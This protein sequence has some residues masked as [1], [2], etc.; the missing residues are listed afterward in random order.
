MQDFCYV[1]FAVGRANKLRAKD[2]PALKW[3]RV[4]MKHFYKVLIVF[5]YA[6]LMSTGGAQ[7]GLQSESPSLWQEF[8]K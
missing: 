2:G 8:G 5:A 7:A 3:K 1:S 6:L 4:D